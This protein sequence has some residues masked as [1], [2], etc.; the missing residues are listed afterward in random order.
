MDPESKEFKGYTKSG[1][2][3]KRRPK[4]KNVYFTDDTQ[5]A[6]LEYNASDNSLEREKIY[7]RRIHY[8]FFK[9]TENIIHTF[10]FYHTEVDTI[11]DLQHEVIEFLLQKI[12]LYNPEK[13][14]A[15]SYFGTI[16][17]RYLIAYNQKNYNKLINSAEVVEVNN[18]SSKNVYMEIDN[19]LTTHDQI[20]EFMDKY[21]EYVEGNL[22]ELF[23]EKDRPIADAIMELFRKR[24]AIDVFNKKALY[25]Y[26][27]EMVDVKTIHI[28]RIA[29]RLG[30][31]YLDAFTRYKEYGVVSFD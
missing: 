26:I 27:R 20:S 7:H 22:N 16:A 13:G 12:H 31:I 14:R 6:I 17:K 18:D 11:E 23:S 25:I 2:P 10:K 1:K 9:L 28:T 19:P 29:K 24:E 21:I 8:A 3:R 15:Y 4:K 30:D 5:A